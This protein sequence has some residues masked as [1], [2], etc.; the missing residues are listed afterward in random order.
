[1]T[2]PPREVATGTL[3]HL[4]VKKIEWLGAGLFAPKSRKDR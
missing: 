2:A 3:S 4:S 1:M